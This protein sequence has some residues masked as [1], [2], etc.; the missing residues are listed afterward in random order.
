VWTSLA[1]WADW[2]FVLCR[3]DPDAPKHKGISYLLVRM[4]APGIELR[5][6]RQ[7]TG[8][9]EFNEVFFDEVRTPAENVVGEVNGG[10]KVAMGTL[11]FE[12]STS[13]LGQQ[14]IFEREVDEI[15][16]RA[17]ES[18]RIDDPVFRQRLVGLLSRLR[19]MRWNTLRVLSG[20]QDSAQLD[21]AAMISKLFWATLHR[22]IGEL[23]VDVLG[24][25]ATV[26]D[27]APY[28]LSL[29]QRLFLY[30]RADTIYGGAN[31]IQRTII[32]ERALGL[33]REPR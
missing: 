28:D 20:A 16:H 24:V 26:A 14:L 31:Q 4:D 33:P 27:G 21:G 30:T 29:A 2:C 19:I 17:R 9:A 1:H 10:W 18:G 8:T 32:G 13:T 6:I 3:T 22:D 5:P 25:D 15:V 12:R 11:A 23:A 7:V